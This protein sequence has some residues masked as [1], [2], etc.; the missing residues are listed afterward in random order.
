MRLGLG[1]G[2]TRYGVGGVGG[3]EGTPA[4]TMVAPPTISGEFYDGGTVWVD[5]G[6]YNPSTGLTGQWVSGATDPP[7]TPISGATGASLGITGLGGQ[8]LG[9]LVTPANGEAA[10]LSNVVRVH[11]A[12]M[13]APVLLRT[14]ASGA[15][16]FTYTVTYDNTVFADDIERVQY[17]SDINFTTIL[18]DATRG[19][20]E[21]A[22]AAPF[23]SDETV[24]ADPAWDVPP[25]TFTGT[26]FVR[27]KAIAL[28]GAVESG[29]SN[30]ESNFVI[31]LT[32]KL[33]PGASWDNPNPG[34]PT[35]KYTFS[36]D[37]LTF[38][39]SSTFHAHA[40]RVN[41]ARTGRCTADMLVNTAITGNTWLG[42]GFDDG[43]FDWSTDPDNSQKLINQVGW[44]GVY[45]RL[46]PDYTSLVKATGTTTVEAGGGNHAAGFWQ[47]GDKLRI[48]YTPGTFT[49]PTPNNNGTAIV[50]RIRS[51]AVTLACNITGIA[52]MASHKV[53]FGANFSGSGTFTFDSL[54]PAINV[55]SQEYQDAS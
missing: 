17:A 49:G 30:T 45:L 28:D 34:E 7:S 21:A 33:D 13:T 48:D 8:Y 27:R 47:V 53:I 11:Y 50:E 15:S 12:T 51:G 19:L 46:G 20:T 52:S 40:G 3:G 31:D 2:L 4:T 9:C 22:F 18:W 36:G 5:Y 10:R 44:K 39:S 25:P 29:W 1:L 54:T 43:A 37:Q 38:T 14:S 42:F 6:S 35:D 16:P 55:A 41:Y 26:Y 32:V 23:T 24:D